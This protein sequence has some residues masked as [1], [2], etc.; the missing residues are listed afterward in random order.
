MT[1]NF[2]RKYFCLKNASLTL[3][4]LDIVQ[5]NDQAQN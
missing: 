5:I 1:I 3:Q 2:T 4:H